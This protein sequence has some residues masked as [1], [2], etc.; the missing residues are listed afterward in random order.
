MKGWK[1]L[2]ARRWRRRRVWAVL[3]GWG[4]PWSVWHPERIAPGYALQDWCVAV[5]QGELPVVETYRWTG[6]RRGRL[7]SQTAL[8]EVVVLN[9]RYQLGIRAECGNQGVAWGRFVG[10][11]DVAYSSL[12]SALVGAA[13]FLE[14]TFG[15]H[16]CVVWAWQ[17]AR[18]PRL[19]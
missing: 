13:V 10:P 19:L 7:F 2:H 9:G 6:K 8:I 3:L 1:V 5:P 4:L 17:L 14:E 16:E 15:A 11:C 12:Q 18:Q